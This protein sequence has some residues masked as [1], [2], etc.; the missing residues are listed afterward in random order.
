MNIFFF[1]CE[2]FNDFFWFIYWSGKPTAD[3]QQFIL[4]GTEVA[5]I[6]DFPYQLSLRISHVHR[7]G[8]SVI[9]THFALS[10]AHCFP[11]NVSPGLV[12]IMRKL[13]S[14]SLKTWSFR[15]HLEL[16]A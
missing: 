10:A 7:C 12:N 9:A 6:A 15:L 14:K 5:D 2:S 4:G 16:A 11:G 1:C 3:L 8:A 13:F